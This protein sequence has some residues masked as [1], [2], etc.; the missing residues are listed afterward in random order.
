M[1]SPELAAA[2][3]R[4]AQIALRDFDSLTSRDQEA[5]LITLIEFAHGPE[6]QTAEASLYH[7]REAAT[8]QLQLKALIEGIGTTQA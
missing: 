6:A 1:P 7:R 8:Q 5:V 4:T 2:I 3:H